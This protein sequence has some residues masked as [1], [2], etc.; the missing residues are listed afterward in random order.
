[1]YPAVEGTDHARLAL[2]YGLLRACVAGVLKQLRDGTAGERCADWVL[3][4]LS[5]VGYPL[6][7]VG[8]K[9]AV[10]LFATLVSTNG[11]GYRVLFSLPAGLLGA[12]GLRWS[13]ICRW[14][15]P[16][17]FATRLI[18][19]LAQRRT[20]KDPVETM[21]NSR[22]NCKE[23]VGSLLSS[24]VEGRAEGGEG[25]AQLAAWQR[26]ERRLAKC[27]VLAERLPKVAAALDLKRLLGD[28][29][30]GGT[31]LAEVRGRV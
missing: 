6:V 24:L 2:L 5:Y 28:G 25:A 7:S 27:V 17:A 10:G 8:L 26:R 11:V 29:E 20:F 19:R 16:N 23:P 21:L 14:S 12:V 1:V 18:H 3:N 15:V 13:Q 9:P 22:L 30:G 4:S 31:A